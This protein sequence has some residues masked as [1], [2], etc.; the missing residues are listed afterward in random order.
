MRLPPSF[1]E[2]GPGGLPT[3]YLP[4]ADVRPAALADERAGG[5]RTWTVV[6]GRQRVPRGAWTHRDPTGDLAA[7]DG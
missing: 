4:K 2:Y 6:A 1:V 5:R 3:Y 7:L